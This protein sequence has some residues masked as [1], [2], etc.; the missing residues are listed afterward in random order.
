MKRGV[1][2]LTGAAMLLTVACAGQRPQL[3]IKAMPGPISAATK[4]VPLRVA[5]AQSHLAL[6]N[7][8]LALESFRR[9]LR[10][11]PESVDALLGIATCYDRMARYD[12]ARRNFEAALALEPRNPQLLGA[13]AASLERQGKRVQA[14]AIMSEIRGIALALPDIQPATLALPNAADPVR[15]PLAQVAITSPIAPPAIFDAQAAPPRH[16]SMARASVIMSLPPPREAA[17]VARPADATAAQT[18]A[19]KPRTGPRLERLS[20]GEVALVTSHQPQFAVRMVERTQRSTT[21]R[22]LPLKAAVASRPGPIRLLNA[23]RYPKLAANARE[24]LAERGWRGLAIGD[25]PSVRRTSLIL[26]PQAHRATAERLAAQFGYSVD[27][28]VSGNAIVVLLG[29]DAVG[30]RARAKRS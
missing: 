20:P 28:R 3:A 25:A 11:E 7:I 8:A 21:L 29:R 19:P 24:M 6:G 1:I 2:L 17:A 16:Q 9:A 5:E 12:L 22:F 15:Q 14:E 26:Y 18:V 23:A 10:D 13:M 27:R 30:Q 4:P